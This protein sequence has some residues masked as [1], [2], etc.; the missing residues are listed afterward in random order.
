MQAVDDTASISA[1]T[2][3]K[4][5][6]TEKLMELFGENTV[7]QLTSA[8]WKERLETVNDLLSKAKGMDVSRHASTLIQGVAHVP[9]WT[10]KNFQVRDGS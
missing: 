8:Q 6:A 1:G 7:E 3:T 2:M 4:D 5:T 9:G 10:E